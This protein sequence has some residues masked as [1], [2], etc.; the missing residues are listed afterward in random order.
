MR[1]F[2]WLWSK[3]WLSTEPKRDRSGYIFFLSAYNQNLKRI[4]G[5]SDFLRGK[6]PVNRPTARGTLAILE[7]AEDRGEL[8]MLKF[9]RP[10]E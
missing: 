6:E 3:I 5:V 7:K 2:K 10:H 8:D 1:F 4:C 9:P